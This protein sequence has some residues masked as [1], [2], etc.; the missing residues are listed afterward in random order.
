[1]TLT[2]RT[3]GN[4]LKLP[5]PQTR[6]ITRD[7]A[8][9][10]PMPDGVRLLADR[11]Y[12]TD[13][14][15]GLPLLVARTPYGRQ[16]EGVLSRLL[17]ERGYQTLL[18]SC[19]G[20][21]GSG[22]EWNPFRNEQA[23]GNAVLAWIA[24]QS[25]FGGAMGL[26]GP[27]YVG[28]TQWA[29][30]GN[31]P[32]TVKAICPMV[33]SSYFAELF[34]PGGSF[35]L[36]S[37]LTWIH[38]LRHQEESWPRKIAAVA[39][40]RKAIASAA[41]KL[42]VADLD[43]T[44]TGRRMEAFQDWLEHPGVDDPW[45]SAVDFGRDLT[46]VPPASLTGGWYDIFLPYQVDDYVALRQAGRD[47]RLAIGPWDHSTPK[48]TGHNARDTLDWM[49]RHVAG[50]TPA[51][52][53]DRVRLYVMGAE[54]WVGY[55]EWPPPASEQAWYL[56]PGG[57]LGTEVPPESEP[58][59]FRYDPADPTPSIGGA[60]LQAGAAGRKDNTKLE[61]RPDVLTFTSE[62]MT[63]DLTVA[64]PLRADLH[65]RS[66]LEH[67]D[68][69]VRLCEVD[70]Q[71]RSFNLADGILRV[72][73]GASKS[74]VKRAKDGTMKVRVEM[75]PTANTFR[76]GYRIR[77]QVSSGAH[78]LYIRN[79]GSGEP[80]GKGTTLVVAEQEVCHDPKRPSAIILP[81]LAEPIRPE[82]R[83]R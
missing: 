66:S 37:S 71:G 11:W 15:N 20:T 32:D 56:Q 16:F 83:D 63:D 72:G 23:D 43:V 12:P 79:L 55:D 36:L 70:P 82:S 2:S 34:Y 38:G 46:K 5:A 14:P 18:V 8:I 58:D 30:A 1:M 28:L 48:A 64:G 13:Q 68:F 61:A 24:E 39:A 53:P 41:T 19:R 21:F 74:Q 25:W 57:K 10:I 77:L 75:W 40:G 60:S 59:R 69:F 65:V 3:L 26:Y 17:A 29:V 80:L 78:P 31:P 67:T 47:A 51:S 27:S 81:V 44:V 49:D 9:E 7:R 45:W 62:P 6:E 54:R 73:S 50:R 42:P 35:T 76:C 22:G 4:L 52:E 33:T